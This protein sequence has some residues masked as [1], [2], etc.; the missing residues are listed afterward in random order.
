[1]TFVLWTQFHVERPWGQPVVEP[2][3]HYTALVSLRSSL[4]RYLLS[5]IPYSFPCL[6]FYIF[7]QVSCLARYGSGHTDV[8]VTEDRDTAERFLGA[9]DSACVFH[10]TSSRFA[11]GFR[12]GLGAE[13]R[14]NT[15]KSEILP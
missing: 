3:E 9:V 5:N 15:T 10:N 8:I 4:N 1:M 11:D 6:V 13:V 2:M 14:R 12:L 7:S